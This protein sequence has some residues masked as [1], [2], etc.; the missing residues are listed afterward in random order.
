[1]YILTRENLSPIYLANMYLVYYSLFIQ[2][3][4]WGIITLAGCENYFIRVHEN[5]VQHPSNSNISIAFSKSAHGR[6]RYE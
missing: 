2:G 3:V 6:E 5:L 1:M 4:D